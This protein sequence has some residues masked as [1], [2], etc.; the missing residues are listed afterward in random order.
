MGSLCC[1]RVLVDLMACVLFC[2]HYP[3]AV[4]VPCPPLPFGPCV[5][6]WRVA[7]GVCDRLRTASRSPTLSG[8]RTRS[9]RT[10]SLSRKRSNSWWSPMSLHPSAGTA[11][12]PAASA[13]T[14][15]G[16]VEC[17]KAAG[18]RPPTTGAAE[19]DQVCGHAAGKKT[20][21]S[22]AARSRITTLAGSARLPS[23]RRRREAGPRTYDASSTIAIHMHGWLFR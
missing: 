4:C 11:T 14:M 17:T 15:H 22:P 16:H 5:C 10:E 3:F 20:K 6:V 1:R 2:T 18:P 13:T 8:R 19:N 23:R 21:A 12:W 9:T 7:C